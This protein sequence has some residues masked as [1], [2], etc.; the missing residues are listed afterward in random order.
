MRSDFISFFERR[1]HKV[2]PSSP[3]VPLDDPTLLFTNAGMNQF[4]PVFLGTEKRAYSRA[5]NAQKCIRVSGKHNDLEEVGHDSY[6]H[7]FFEMLGNWSF[8]DY[9][10]EDAI[11]WAWDLL[12]DHWGLPKPRLY[13]TVYQDDDEAEQCWKTATDIDHS[14]IL[15][16]GEKDNF[17]EMGDTGPCGPC[18]EIH[19][20]L[21]PEGRGR[22]LVNAGSPEVIELWNLVFIQYNRHPDGSLSILPA[23]HVDTGAGFERLA[24][25]LQGKAS[26]YDID[27]FRGIIAGIENRTKKPYEGSHHEA[28]FRVIADHV[29]MLTFSICDGAIPGN[30]GRGYVLRRILRRAAMYGRKLEMHDP[31]LCDIV[32]DVVHVMGDAYPEIAARQVHVEKT[33]RTEEEHFNRTL[34]RGL[35]L[36]EDIV[37][38]QKTAGVSSISGN[39]AFRLYDTFGFPL[40]LTRVMANE[41][42]MELD[43]TGFQQAMDAQR[44]RSREEGKKKFIAA[45]VDWSL[46]ADSGKS[47]F[48]GYDRFE[49]DTTIVKY[50]IEAGQ[51]RLVFAETPFYAE[52]GGQVGDKGTLTLDGRIVE[53][54]DTQKAG[55]DIVHFTDAI[56]GMNV[57][58]SKVVHLAVHRSVRLETMKNHSATHLLHSALR[59][60]LGNHVQQAGSLVDADRLRFDFTHSEKLSPSQIDRIE[61]LVIDQI[62]QNVPLQHHRN[63]P[64]AEARAMGALSFFGDK[65]GDHVNVVQFSDFSKEFCGGTHVPST[66]VISHFRILSESAIA[67]G[68]RRIE[69][70]TGSAAERLLR[71]E[72]D[73]SMQM[74]QLLGVPVDGLLAK[75]TALLEENRTLVKERGALQME[76]VMNRIDL[77]VSQQKNSS[78]TTWITGTV[79]LP[80]GVDIKAVGDYVRSRMGSGVGVLAALGKHSN[81]LVCV[82][83][84]D[85]VEKRQWNA[86]ML[87]KELASIV[88]GQGGGRPSLAMAGIKDMS[89][90]TDVFSRVKQLAG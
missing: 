39:D 70:V 18:S 66:G 88:G 84:D 72:R 15:R 74:S 1:G 78:I 35:E 4:K 20:D 48:V 47:R 24:R 8:G 38:R 17:W 73:L 12:T 2:V 69:A 76:K 65:Y 29:R 57:S 26:N 16:F 44:Q 13:A 27:L 6:H 63:L 80:D 83:T 82:V 28:A 5:V 41:H 33:I 50:S 59:E 46:V 42:R 53:V 45:S 40:D 23:K 25:V 87:I 75:V 79:E 60:V 58:E 3:V 89:K 49:T 67:S 37:R 62:R 85:L 31:F 7:T 10:K 77:L 9:Y 19:I 22:D 54:W 52:A 32:K 81:T 51:G 64:I 21:T 90:L 68:V 71:Y 43:E 36:F 30:D 14:H 11:K 34:D 56:E 55:D 86:G 61:Q